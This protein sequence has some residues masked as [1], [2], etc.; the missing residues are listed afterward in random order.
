MQWT[1]DDFDKLV[2]AQEVP[3]GE[4]TPFSNKFIPDA[5]TH[6]YPLRDLVRLCIGSFRSKFAHTVDRVCI[7]SLL[8]IPHQTRDYKQEIESVTVF[9]TPHQV[10]LFI[11]I[12]V[13]QAWVWLSDII[14]KLAAFWS[15]D[16][17]SSNVSVTPP[18]LFAN[19]VSL[20]EAP[21][22][23]K[24]LDQEGP[25]LLYVDPLFFTYY[26]LVAMS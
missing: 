14:T 26:G 21:V 24:M 12:N 11:H 20:L 16:T 13:E 10:P 17:R 7:A 2:D 4:S 18:S 22:T 23:R 1:H 8:G 3:R 25:V 15:I 5:F 6:N 9:E 19:I